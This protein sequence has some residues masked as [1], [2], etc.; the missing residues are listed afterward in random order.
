MR[1]PRFHRLLE[2]MGEIHDRKNNDYAHSG[3]PYSNFEE[4][5]QIAGCPVDTVFRVLIGVKLA[6]LTVL[7]GDGVEPRNESADDSLLD[8][9]VYAALWASYR[10]RES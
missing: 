1:N 8:L 7:L 9:A 10:D 4:A 2:R 3:S 6:R 5:A